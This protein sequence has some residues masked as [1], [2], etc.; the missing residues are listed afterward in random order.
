MGKERKIQEG[1]KNVHNELTYLE[2]TSNLMRMNFV[3]KIVREQLIIHGRDVVRVSFGLKASKWLR[4][5]GYAAEEFQERDKGKLFIIL[6]F[7]NIFK[8]VILTW[9]INYAPTENS[10]WFPWVIVSTWVGCGIPSD[11]SRQRFSKGLGRLFQNSIIIKYGFSVPLGVRRASLK[12]QRDV[13]HR[14]HLHSDPFPGVLW[15]VSTCSFTVSV[16]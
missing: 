10:Q 2:E 7:S 4:Q 6:T 3:E 13:C 8:I 11:G 9:H 12:W 14:R 1:A 16:K 5:L 15:K